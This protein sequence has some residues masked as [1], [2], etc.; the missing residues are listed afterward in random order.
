MVAAA[1]EP[2][3][4]EPKA[5]MAGEATGVAASVVAKAAV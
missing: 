1:K 2:M 5:P 4:A 3:V